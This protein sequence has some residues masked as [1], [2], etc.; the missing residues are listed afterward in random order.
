MREFLESGVVG[1][2]YK[3]P[4]FYEFNYSEAV[5]LDNM[6]SYLKEVYERWD[7]LGF[8]G[9]L[10][11]DIQKKCAYAFEQLAQYLIYE[12]ASDEDRKYFDETNFETIG[13]PITRRTLTTIDKDGIEFDF[14]K[15]VEYYKQFNVN[16]VLDVVKN[17]IFNA[18][19]DKEAEAVA[20]VSMMIE[21]KF[22]NPNKSSDDI[23]KEI[24]GNFEENNKRK[25]NNK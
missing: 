10:E 2:I 22:K 6:K 14:K 5:E 17:Y 16:D 4:K 19:I 21:E 24:V 7:R 15:F 8:T 12:V 20:M 13:F 1:K 23:R 18:E 25:E 3:K 9:G 11:G